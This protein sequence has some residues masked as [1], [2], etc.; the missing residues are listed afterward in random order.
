MVEVSF[1]KRLLELEVEVGVGSEDS[2]EEVV[3][4]VVESELEEIEVV[5]AVVAD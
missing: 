2:I 1:G 3:V 4:E 5:L